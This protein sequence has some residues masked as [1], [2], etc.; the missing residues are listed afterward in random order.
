M[1]GSR[2]WK[3]KTK[4][5][6]GNKLLKCIFV[7]VLQSSLIE[8]NWCNGLSVYTICILKITSDSF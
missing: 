2:G 3:P 6:D 4:I 5:D 8:N 1:S 7:S